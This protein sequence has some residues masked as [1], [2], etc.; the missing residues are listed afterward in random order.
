MLHP[1]KIVSIPRSLFGPTKVIARH[2]VSCLKSTIDSRSFVSSLNKARLRLQQVLR[3]IRK[4]FF[5]FLK[6]ISIGIRIFLYAICGSI[7]NRKNSTN[8]FILDK[9][10]SILKKISFRCRV[11]FWIQNIRFFYVVK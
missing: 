4:N 5:F 9:K 6:N 10:L 11:E 7:L 3:Q 1:P 2:L 8:L